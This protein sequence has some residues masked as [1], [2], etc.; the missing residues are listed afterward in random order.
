MTDQFIQDITENLTDE[1]FA[2]F[3][4]MYESYQFQELMDQINNEQQ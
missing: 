1:Q 4:K 3:M 2:Q